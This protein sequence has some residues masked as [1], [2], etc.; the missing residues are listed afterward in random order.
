MFFYTQNEKVER[1][2]KDSAKISLEWSAGLDNNYVLERVQTYV[3]DI[4][5]I[6]VTNENGKVVKYFPQWQFYDMN[7]NLI[8]EANYKKNLQLIPNRKGKASL[9]IEN[10]QEWVSNLA[11]G[12]AISLIILF[13]VRDSLKDEDSYTFRYSTTIPAFDIYNAIFGTITSDVLYYT[14]SKKSSDVSRND[15]T[16]IF[17]PDRDENGWG[18]PANGWTRYPQQIKLTSEY[19]YLWSYHAYT[20]NGYTNTT[21]TDPVLSGSYAESSIVTIDRVEIKYGTSDNG[22]LIENNGIY[23]PQDTNIVWLSSIQNV[24]GGKYI[25]SKTTTYYSIGEPITTYTVT[26]MGKDGEDG[27]DGANAISA[28]IS[29]TATAF[30]NGE[31]DNITLTC[32]LY[33]GGDEINSGITYQWLV[34][35][36]EQESG[37]K[38][39]P[40]TNSTFI[41]DYIINP[42][43]VDGSENFRCVCTYNNK[44]Y[45]DTITIIDMT[46]P[47]LVT[48][49]SDAG[50]I[51]RNGVGSTQ[52][53][54][55]LFQSG[56]EI[57]EDASEYDYYWIVYDKDGNLNTNITNQINNETNKPYKTITIDSDMV[58]VKNTFVCEVRKKD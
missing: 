29:T 23:Q 47:V 27:E 22:Q 16:G 46:D 13:V 37:W 43:M 51:F 6:Y 7:D 56:I 42:D 33:S 36:S 3:D 44:T 15:N 35:D 53:T 11:Y 10:L 17:Y 5:Y 26:Y 58:N 32:L 21:Y 48:I 1:I 19:P 8:C 18:E 25:W 14:A 45:S 2:S 52:L 38:E 49:F 41:K 30:K 9:V 34:Q 31:G 50:D 24:D 20:K 57:D 28:K 55:K 54:A 12:D 4:Y 40:K 39:L